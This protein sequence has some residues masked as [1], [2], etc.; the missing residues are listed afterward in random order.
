[1]MKADKKRERSIEESEG[2]SL[3]FGAKEE[4]YMNTGIEQINDGNSQ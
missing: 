1:M 4:S 2:K 3:N